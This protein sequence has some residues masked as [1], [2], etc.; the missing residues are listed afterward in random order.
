MFSLKNKF[1]HLFA[2][3]TS[4]SDL[5][6]F[7]FL[8]GLT[9]FRWLISLLFF[10]FFF[11]FY[12]RV[13]LGLLGLLLDGGGSEGVHQDPLCLGQGPQFDGE[14]GP[15]DG[16]GPVDHQVLQVRVPRAAPFQPGGQDR[17]KVPTRGVE[18]WEGQRQLEKEL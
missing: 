8:S 17:V 5:F 6:H 3:G 14:E 13:S 1:L 18:S 7:F 12:D 2:L 11:F 10:F 16:P 9:Q 15:Q 4:F